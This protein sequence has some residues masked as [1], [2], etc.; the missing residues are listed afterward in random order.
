VRKTE[1]ADTPTNVGAARTAQGPTAG[2]G[3]RASRYGFAAFWVLT[4][5]AA[6]TGLRLLLLAKFAPAGLTL[7]VRARALLAGLH[8]DALVA[9][10]CTLPT[11]F[12]FWVLP[13]RRFAARWHRALFWGMH[14][15]IAGVGVFLL[16]VEYYFFEE[17]KSRFNTV[18]VDYVL[19]PHEVFVNIWD[20][21]P[22][23]P[24]VAGCA[25]V[26]AMWV[27]WARR[28]FAAMWQE[29]VRARWRLAW[30]AGAL[31]AAVGLSQ[32]VAL[33]GAKVSSDR[34]LNEIANNGGLAL[35]S[36]ALTRHLDYAAFY[37]TLDRAE[38][39]ARVR[40]LL[41]SPTAE[42]VGGDDSLRRR[43]RGDPNRPRLNVVILLEESLGSEFWGCLGRPNTLTPEMDRLATEEGLLFTN[44]Y[45]CGNRTVRGLEGVLASFPPLPGDSIVARDLSDHVETLARVLKR[46]G[47]STLFLYGGRGLFDGMKTFA[48]KNGFDRF[49][50]HNP[51]FQDD[52]PNPGFATVW[53]VCDEEV[54]DR[55][56]AEFRALAQQGRPFFGTVLTVSNHKPYTYPVG[57]IPEDPNQRRRA[58]AVKYSD[59]AL[60]RFFR[61]AKQEAFWTNTIFV[62][63]ADHGARVYGSQSIPIRSY[64]IPLV[65]LGPAVVKAPARLGM[66]GS[67]LDV[68]PTVLGLIGRPYET[69]F[70]GRDLL[71]D[72]PENGRAPVHHNRDIGLFT[73]NRLV[74]LGL[75][76]D[77]DFYAGDP[78]TGG[79][80][81][82]TLIT[83]RDR[84]LERDT[85]ALFQVAD[86]LYTQQR[87][88]LP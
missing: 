79:L 41:A 55:A 47:Y 53:G 88:R 69:L 9:L 67:S 61:A 5:L 17:F 78:K 25:A 32:T 40:R 44:I 43:V 77:S 13:Q 48:L 76:R 24:V 37:K 11:L 26:A 68:A 7:S 4:L 20:S 12:W 83:P 87:Y 63:V 28:W 54:F 42:F 85:I 1:T 49:L 64:E 51:P 65:I 6:W 15:L 34:T 56:I 18:A 14:F 81:P 2:G 80:T 60:G 27:W 22:V 62:V 59:W 82:L 45:A 35:A 10:I 8:R 39:Y 66:L 29:T 19:Y 52:F 33:K 84:E 21:Y 36:A 23:V 38:A 3:W 70:F 16:A 58:H 73:Q 31:V 86:E 50:E 57:R 72:P 46:D 30:F 75:L 71:H 74:V